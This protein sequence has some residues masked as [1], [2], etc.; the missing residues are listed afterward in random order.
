MRKKR[1][2]EEIERKKEQEELDEALIKEAE[3][4]D[5]ETVLDATQEIQIKRQTLSTE[6][7]TT[8]RV[9]KWRLIDIDKV[10]REYL[11][12]NETLINGIRKERPFGAVSHIDGIEFYTDEV[13]RL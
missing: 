13:A 2:L 5:D 6:H 12:L 8:M 9:K 7:L 4:F 11:T 10:P 1:E 3:I